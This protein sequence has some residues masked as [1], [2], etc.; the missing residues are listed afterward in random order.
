MNPLL[1]RT[2]LAV[3]SLVIIPIFSHIASA[4]IDTVHIVGMKFVPATLKIKP[5]TT[6][7]WYN[8]TNMLH[9]S[10]SGTNCN[11]DGKWN[12][13][14][15]NQGKYFKHTF[16]T[17]GRY[18][19]FCL[20]HCLSGMKGMIIVAAPPV[21]PAPKPQAKTE[22]KKTGNEQKEVSEKKET[23][24]NPVKEETKGTT[25]KKSTKDTVAN[26]KGSKENNDTEAQDT[27]QNG[28]DTTDIEVYTK[29]F[30]DTRV[31]TAQSVETLGMRLLDVRISHRFDD[32]A[33]PLGG[34]HH[35][36]GL[37][38]I[39]DVRLAL[40]YGISD[41]LMIGIARD[42]GDYDVFH[43]TQIRELYEL[44]GKY[45]ILRQRTDGKVPLSLT[46]HGNIVFSAM[47]KDTTPY[48][49]AH[50]NSEGNRFS[51]ELQALAARKF[52]KKFS[53]EIMPTYIRRN[54]T[55]FGDEA[56]LF[57]LGAGARYSFNERFAVVADYFYPFSGFRQARNG[58]YQNPFGIGL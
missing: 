47:K 8:P 34:F 10:T 41:N 14:F 15:I 26:K 21:K 31:V 1:S 11:P 27:S 49:E 52:N 29:I 28:S 56:D 13:G 54:W 55:T 35:F 43:E 37:D 33:A 46:L 12:S 25:A 16:K 48:S 30:A 22:E 42:K 9:T 40:E 38:N 19:Y 51:F 4:K 57:A 20:P 45:R 36:Y 44:M 6:V 24:E 17:A 53:L 5:G 50:F 3:L 2:L 7:V 32:I 39:R 58:E 23:K 18:P